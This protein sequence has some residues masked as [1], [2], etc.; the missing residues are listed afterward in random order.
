MSRL[1]NYDES[2]P[3]NNPIIQ[4]PN[5]HPSNNNKKKIVGC[6]EVSQGIYVSQDV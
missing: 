3:T 5:P 6:I 2:D 4:P 1:Q